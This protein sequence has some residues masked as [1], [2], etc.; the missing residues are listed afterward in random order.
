MRGAFAI[1]L[2]AGAATAALLLLATINDS[3]AQINAPTTIV[4][5][6]PYMIA[7]GEMNTVWRIDQSSGR[8]SICQYQVTS[9]NPR[10]LADRKPFCSAWS[11]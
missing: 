4:T 7:A 6:G 8:V 10:D 11:D 2:F 5:N 3:R 1:A 9:N